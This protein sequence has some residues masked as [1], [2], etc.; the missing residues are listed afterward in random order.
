MIHSVPNFPPVPNKGLSSKHKI[1]VDNLLSNSEYS[2]PTSGHV[3]GQSFLCISLKAN[4]LDIVGR[5]LMYSQIIVYR[6]NLP[7]DLSNQ[8][9]NLTDAAN[10]IRIKNPPYNNK[11]VIKSSASLEF[12]S[13]AKSDKWQRGI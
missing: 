11:E 8:Y 10:Q 1:T 9:P 7:E 2:Y 12:V 6:K 4:Q 5:Q 13:F 3:R